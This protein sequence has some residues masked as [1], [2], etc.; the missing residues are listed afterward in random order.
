[1]KNTGIPKVTKEEMQHHLDVLIATN[2]WRRDQNVPPTY[3]MPDPK[4]I[5]EAIDFAIEYIKT[6]MEL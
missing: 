5:G 3:P 4:E 6:F 2:H 1:M